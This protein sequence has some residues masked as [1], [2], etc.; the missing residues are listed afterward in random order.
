M[1]V[2][3]LAI[4]FWGLAI[5]VTALYLAAKVMNKFGIFNFTLVFGALLLSPIGV[6][7]VLHDLTPLSW[8]RINSD[9]ALQWTAFVVVADLAIVLGALAYFIWLDPV[10]NILGSSRTDADECQ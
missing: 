9:P 8:T 4:F 1:E 6:P 2:I 3:A 10:G 7:I 5:I